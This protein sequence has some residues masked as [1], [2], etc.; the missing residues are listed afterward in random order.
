MGS[1]VRLK[2]ASPVSVTAAAT[3]LAARTGRVRPVRCGSR[4]VVGGRRSTADAACGNRS[5]VCVAP[6]RL[7]V[8]L[9]ARPATVGALALAGVRAAALVVA[10][11]RRCAPPL[12]PLT[13]LYQKVRRKRN[14]IRRTFGFTAPLPSNGFLFARVIIT[15]D[16]S[17]TKNCVLWL[18]LSVV[19]CYVSSVAAKGG[20]GVGRI[21]ASVASRDAG[22]SARRFRRTFGALSAL[23]QTAHVGPPQRRQP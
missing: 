7:V 18:I 8:A 14:A 19:C 23:R 16:E 17:P 5:A 21:G 13:P 4:A 22:V 1:R 9:V 12:Q 3:A 15:W 20:G 10:L 11:V 6:A 2:T